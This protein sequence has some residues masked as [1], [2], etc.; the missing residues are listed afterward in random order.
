MFTMT[1]LRIY[2]MLKY[3]QRT[4]C[5]YSNVVP[6]TRGTALVGLDPKQSGKLPQI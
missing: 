6:S 4:F 2:E 5:K 3:I 1:I